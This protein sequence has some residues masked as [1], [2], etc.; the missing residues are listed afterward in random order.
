[1]HAVNYRPLPGKGVTTGEVFMAATYV[2]RLL[3]LTFST[4]WRY[5]I[6]WNLRI[7]RQSIFKNFS[8]FSAIIKAV[9]LY[10]IQQV[11]LFLSVHFM[12]FHVHCGSQFRKFYQLGG[13]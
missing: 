1:M 3:V 8:Q 6:L 5:Y 7:M 13:V 4:A 10:N 11:F 2:L 9:P 12:R